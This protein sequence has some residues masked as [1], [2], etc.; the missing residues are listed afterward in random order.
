MHLDAAESSIVIGVKTFLLQ[1]K[2]YEDAVLTLDAT[3]NIAFPAFQVV[4]PF[5]VVTHSQG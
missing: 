5:L 4:F 2:A 1:P 3:V